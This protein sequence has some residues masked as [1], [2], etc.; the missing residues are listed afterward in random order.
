MDVKADIG[1]DVVPSC[2]WGKVSKRL[3]VQVT[4]LELCKTFVGYQL[5]ATRVIAKEGVCP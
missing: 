4:I 5:K 1:F 2:I 3:E